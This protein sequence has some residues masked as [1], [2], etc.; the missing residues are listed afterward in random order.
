MSHECVNEL[1]RQDFSKEV[2]D[3][4]LVAIDVNTSGNRKQQTTKIQAFLQ[5]HWQGRAKSTSSFLTKKL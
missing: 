1:L 5:I 2:L 4:K 3:N